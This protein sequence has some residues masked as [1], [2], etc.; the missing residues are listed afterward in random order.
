MTKSSN[1]SV[2]DIRLIL[3]ECQLDNKLNIIL[4]ANRI[5]SIYNKMSLVPWKLL[6]NYLTWSY[7]KLDHLPSFT[8]SN[9]WLY[10]TNGL[11]E[12]RNCQQSQPQTEISSAA[13][14]IYINDHILPSSSAILNAIKD[15]ILPKFAENAHLWNNIDTLFRFQQYLI[16][17][18]CIKPISDSEGKK[19][20]LFIEELLFNEAF[21]VHLYSYMATVIHNLFS[22][23]S[24]YATICRFIF[25]KILSIE[26][27]SI[28]KYKD[29]SESD[30]QLRRN[31]AVHLVTE[32]LW[33]YNG[34]HC[35]ELTDFY[36]QILIHSISSL[37]TSIR[38]CA[39][40]C[41]GFLCSLNKPLG[42]RS[43]PLLISALQLDDNYVRNNALC[44]FF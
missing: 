12:K 38:A 41:L 14:K 33:Y 22:T 37:S 42:R 13:A 44:A 29:Q 3:D 35:R 17:L 16:V 39:L 32:I 20:Y 15:D 23:D 10:R 6:I 11:T 40:K 26:Q 21:S 8:L 24:R 36:N 19:I 25:N 5:S 7:E 27:V 31:R 9:I 18:S 1:C 28:S 43:L 4:S 30:V 34:R 2:T